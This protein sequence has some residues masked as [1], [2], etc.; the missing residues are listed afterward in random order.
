MSKPVVEGCELE[1]ES[2]LDSD[3]SGD[4][5]FT[6]P[7]SQTEK[8]DSHGIYSGPQ[9]VSITNYIGGPIKTNPETGTELVT[10]GVGVGTM[11]PSN[12]TMKAG[13]EFVIT[14]TD[15]CVVTVTGMVS[16]YGSPPTAAVDYV[17]VKV[18]DPGQ[19]TSDIS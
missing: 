19:D 14:D 4:V 17:T 12:Q 18:S 1:L 10:P 13:G 3:P 6:T 2:A 5:E 15:T 9:T 11:N 8:I 7:A 16:I